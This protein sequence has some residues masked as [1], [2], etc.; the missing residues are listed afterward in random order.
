V[1]RS[2][3]A[4]DDVNKYAVSARFS[5]RKMPGIKISKKPLVVLAGRFIIVPYRLRSNAPPE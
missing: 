1:G 4:S 2:C 5:T 3:G